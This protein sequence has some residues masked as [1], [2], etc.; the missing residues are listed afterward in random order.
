MPKKELD[1]Y[2]SDILGFLFVYGHKIRFN[3]LYDR[4]TKKMNYKIS[5]PTLAEHLKHLTKGKEVLRKIEGKQNVSYQINEKHFANMKKAIETQNEL[6]EIFS[7]NEKRFNEL[8]LDEQLAVCMTNML[9]RNLQQFRVELN[10]GLNPGNEFQSK[11]EVAFI[12]DPIHRFYEKRLFTNSVKDR[13]YGEK[14]LKK[15]DQAIEN[16]KKDLY[17]NPEETKN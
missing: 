11:L 13:E 7:E 6:N 4:L 16:T 12:N 5:R 9:L 2:C 8:S 3:E 17:E 15:L 10:E 14:A 1:K